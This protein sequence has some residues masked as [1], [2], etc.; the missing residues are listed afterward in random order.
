MEKKL[1]I[2]K[3]TTDE[4]FTVE[5]D[6]FDTG[7]GSVKG[8]IINGTEVIGY[9]IQ[10]DRNRNDRPDVDELPVDFVETG[11]GLHEMLD[12]HFHSSF[13]VT[14]A[15][16]GKDCPSF[17]EAS[18]PWEIPS[19]CLENQKKSKS[20]FSE[21][22]NR[23]DKMKLQVQ[24][25]VKSLK[26]TSQRITPEGYYECPSCMMSSW[27]DNSREDCNNI[28]YDDFYICDGLDYVCG[29]GKS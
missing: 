2:C 3:G 22:R 5:S 19:S 9:Y 11:L 25:G 6:N 24:S 27:N 18:R 1:K 4:K 29:T 28:P 23:L 8:E 26:K 12:C 17:N 16:D 7:C 10:R 20:D 15:C 14:R 21:M 13:L